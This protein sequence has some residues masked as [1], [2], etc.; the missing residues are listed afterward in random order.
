MPGIL[1]PEVTVFM[2]GGEEDRKSETDAGTH[3]TPRSSSRP[4]SMSQPNRNHLTP[5]EK[6]MKRIRRASELS[7]ASDCGSYRSDV[8]S[9]G[10]TS[11]GNDVTAKKKRDQKAKVIDSDGTHQLDPQ[12]KQCLLSYYRNF[13]SA[14]ETEELLRSIHECLDDPLSVIDNPDAPLEFDLS[15][16]PPYTKSLKDQIK[17]Y[18]NK[19]QRSTAQIFDLASVVSK[20]VIKR[21]PTLKDKLLYESFSDKD[22]CGPNPQ[23]TIVSLGAERPLSLRIK[24]SNRLTHKVTL[25]PGTMCTMAGKTSLLYTHEVPKGKHRAEDSDS[26]SEQILLFFIGTPTELTDC[27]SDQSSLCGK[28]GTER[29]S[30]AE[31]E[32]HSD[33]EVESQSGEIDEFSMFSPPKLQ[34]TPA[35]ENSPT[36]DISSTTSQKGADDVK[37]YEERMSDVLIRDQEC[38]ESEDEVKCPTSSNSPRNERKDDDGPDPITDIS[39]DAE[40]HNR[41]VISAEE[42][43]QPSQAESAL[44]SQTD[45]LS[46]SQLVQETLIDIKTGMQALAEEVSCLRKE[47][48]MSKE[49]STAADRQNKDIV[50]VK[51]L[52]QKNLTQTSKMSD[53]ITKNFR[54]IEVAHV[55][56]DELHDHIQK[57]KM[58]LKNYYNSAF[59]KEDSKLIQDMHKVITG[60]D[61]PKKDRV[62]HVPRPKRKKEEEEE[63]APRPSSSSSP[64]PPP[65]PAFQ[66]IS[67]SPTS[68]SSSVRNL[69]AASSRRSTPALQHTSQPSTLAP[70]SIRN[71][72]A[73]SSRRNG[74]PTIT[75]SA[76][77][78][79]HPPT[80]PVNCRA[81]APS[82]T[83]QQQ[84]SSPY[85]FKTILITDSIMRHIKTHDSLGVNHHLHHVSKRDTSALNERDLRQLIKR[86]KPDYV[87][88][89]LGINDIAQGVPLLETMKRFCS[90]KS[91]IDSLD[92]TTLLISLPLLT[93]NPDQNNRIRILRKALSDMIDWFEYKGPPRPLW[94]RTL[95]GNSNRN[96]TKDG[97]IVRNYYQRDGVHLSDEGKRII[98]AN[99]RHHIHLMSK[100]SSTPVRTISSESAQPASMRQGHPTERY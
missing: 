69:P 27:E 95:W 74:G 91:F 2:M 28:S 36:R 43:P 56:I 57:F 35:D 29:T 24:K 13:L 33:T 51:D 60:T 34:V 54:D 38:D 59:F 63:E 20:V 93:D 22:G 100:R 73:A 98:Q 14:H 19:I 50:K 88:V 68:A 9:D 40:L 82:Q 32:A 23:I 4:Y 45:G 76:T 85:I 78:Q 52:W 48:E 86:S 31:S 49:I 72:P 26:E 8:A 94:K 3:V 71:P 99:M 65:T 46:F 70:S 41:T 67:H 5:G 25:R 37:P 61:G 18:R 6:V 11:S 84:A 83:S 55:K 90:F 53:L 97:Q 12:K 39:P 47:F 75:Q 17:F 30:Q 87:Y 64:T 7:D 89:H 81:P 42:R 79:S 15:E 80:Q 58:S 62:R 16:D 1:N 96:F 21:L 44:G 10:P 66:D 77:R 92:G